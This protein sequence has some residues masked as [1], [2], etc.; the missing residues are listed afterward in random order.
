MDGM[1]D[2][3]KRRAAPAK[4]NRNIHSDL[5]A[6]ADEISSYFSE[7]KFFGRYL[8]TIKRV[9][10]PRAR[11]IFSEVKDSAC[12]NPG[13]LFFWKC[14]KPPLGDVKGKGQMA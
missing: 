3:L 14:K 9:G 5:H 8:G 6:L 7:R 1:K 4:A 12:D 13:K 11:Q 2:L 10:I